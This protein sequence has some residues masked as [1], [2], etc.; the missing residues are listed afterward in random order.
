M[1][2]CDLHYFAQV[3]TQLLAPLG[4]SERSKLG[5]LQLKGETATTFQKL[6]PETLLIRYAL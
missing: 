4:A 1:S 3:R 2:S 6:S 5:E